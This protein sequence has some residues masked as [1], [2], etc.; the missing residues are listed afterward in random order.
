MNF[1]PRRNGCLYFSFCSVLGSSLKVLWVD[2]WVVFGVKFFVCVV[3]YD[4]HLMSIVGAMA[5]TR[6]EDC[7]LIIM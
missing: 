1:F 6:G 4:A 7:S 5:G 3:Y 2:N